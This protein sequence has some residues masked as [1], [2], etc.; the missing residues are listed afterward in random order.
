MESPCTG[1]KI[2]CR[3]H[4]SIEMSVPICGENPSRGPMMFGSLC[5]DAALVTA[6]LVNKPAPIIPQPTAEDFKKLRRFM[7]CA[8][9][10]DKAMGCFICFSIVV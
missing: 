8:A 10:L 3:I 9:L 2:A 5:A 4:S 1:F 6:W 7:P